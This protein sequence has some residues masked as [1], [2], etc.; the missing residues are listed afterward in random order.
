MRDGTVEET[1]RPSPLQAMAW[2]IR[3]GGKSQRS[4]KARILTQ[5]EG[6][7]AGPSWLGEAQ[8]GRLGAPREKAQILRP[9][10]RSQR[11]H[12]LPRPFGASY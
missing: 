9:E 6:L 5:E 2:E 10:L 11:H 8:A 3:A 4:P 1:S 7:R 12:L